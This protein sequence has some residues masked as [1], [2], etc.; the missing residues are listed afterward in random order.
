MLADQSL[1]DMILHV[2]EALINLI[3]DYGP[4]TY[5]ILWAI[6][7]CE[8]GLVVMPFL[9][10][11]SLL[12]AAGLFSRPNKGL[13][14]KVLLVLLPTASIIGDTVNFHIGKFFGKRLFKSD[15]ARI[16]KKSHLNRTKEFFHHHG[17]KTIIIGRFVPI[18]RTL[19]PFVAGMEAM[20]FRKFFPLSVIGALVWVFICCLAGYYFGGIPW[21]EQNFEKVI[22]IIVGLSFL[23]IAKEFIGTLRKD[24]KK[25]VSAADTITTE[26]T[27]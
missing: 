5:A 6:I 13:D 10:G 15:D 20:T 8:T 16:F 18:V 2:D 9:P 14:I 12:F 7:F 24:R 3:R 19:A 1:I 26:S 23:L 22:L 4:G 25:Q 11:D 17:A 27:P 21:V